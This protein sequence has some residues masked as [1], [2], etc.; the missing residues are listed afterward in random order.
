MS[1]IFKDLVKRY[2][3]MWEYMSG[4]NS[5]VDYR[6]LLESYDDK[7]LQEL[8]L[9]E[10]VDQLETITEYFYS[11][12]NSYEKYKE[13]KDCVNGKLHR[14]TLEKMTKIIGFNIFDYLTMYKDE[15]YNFDFTRAVIRARLGDIYKDEPFTITFNGKS[16]HFESLK[17]ED[18]VKELKYEN[19]SSGSFTIN[20]DNERKNTITFSLVPRCSLVKDTFTGIMDRKQVC[21]I[22]HFSEESFDKFYICLIS[23]FF[24]N[25]R[26]YS[27]LY[28]ELKDFYGYNIDDNNRCY[29]LL[30]DEYDKIFESFE[31][32]IDVE[33]FESTLKMDFDS[34]S[35]AIEYLCL[36]IN[37]FQNLLENK[38][39]KSLYN[40]IRFKSSDYRDISGKDFNTYTTD[41]K[42]A[43]CITITNCNNIKILGIPVL[44]N[45]NN[46]SHT[47]CIYLNQPILFSHCDDLSAERNER[48]YKRHTD[49]KCKK[50]LLDSLISKVNS[51]FVIY[52]HTKH[53]LELERIYHHISELCSY[54]AELTSK[55][56][57][58]EP[59]LAVAK[60]EI[61]VK[62]LELQR[63]DQAILSRRCELDILDQQRR[64]LSFAAKANDE[65]DSIKRIQRLYK[66]QDKTRDLLQ[67]AATVNYYKKNYEVFMMYKSAYVHF[68]K[69]AWKLDAE[70]KRLEELESKLKEETEQKNTELKSLYDKKNQ[71]ISKREKQFDEDCAKYEKES[72]L[73][74]AKMESKFSQ[75]QYKIN[76]FEKIATENAGL[77]SKIKNLEDEKSMLSKQ[78]TKLSN[79]IEVIKGEWK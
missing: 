63:L 25:F 17:C 42:G 67:A 18:A 35:F 6:L 7:K 16:Y 73:W 46:N 44:N 12:P 58:L 36:H 78:V 30:Q 20:Y 5:Q 68:R 52:E 1:E 8:L 51:P 38:K 71:E 60:E 41:V 45:L 29:E 32:G 72:T 2:K 74:K 48:F 37:K 53:Q 27:H 57:A 31:Y 33:T 56:Q 77:K 22:H 76:N 34:F 4:T 59:R 28:P 79:A 69:F 15:Y 70:K 39:V 23:I 10:A 3:V 61:L 55:I 49:A 19:L 40:S 62:Q 14:N 11:I 54:E 24:D 13:I 47:T 66:T 75:F 64:D 21:S 65:Y 9:L 43:Y 50:V 26:T